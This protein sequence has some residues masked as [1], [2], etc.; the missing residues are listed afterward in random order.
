M[1]GE[2]GAKRET[3][4]WPVNLVI[5]DNLGVPL[6]GGRRVNIKVDQRGL[7]ESLREGWSPSA[8][9]GG[10]LT[11]EIPV[12]FGATPA[13]P[14]MLREVREEMEERGDRRTALAFAGV[15]LHW[16]N[17]EIQP[18]GKHG[19]GQVT[20]AEILPGLE[21]L[22]VV[23]DVPGLD[24][25]LTKK[26][27]IQ[28][29]LE[30]MRILLA[31]LWAHEREHILQFIDPQNGAYYGVGLRA[32][33]MRGFKL[34][35]GKLLQVSLLSGAATLPRIW[36]GKEMNRRTFLRLAAVGVLGVG[37]GFLT[38][39]VTG[40]G[41]D[42]FFRDETER[43]ALTAE[44]EWEKYQDCFELTSTVPEGKKAR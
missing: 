2:A 30:E 8:E 11:R 3:D 12:S 40:R 20:H 17:Q 5:R 7:E 44:G 43:L 14:K 1:T 38:D 27:G 41:S 6:T 24:E 34:D 15:L 4:S 9:M 33:R 16:A 35:C 18:A 13:L 32:E 28:T 42:H 39:R 21:Y 23:F 25:F 26:R 22:E 29:S 36:R 31:V 19:A 10:L 37:L